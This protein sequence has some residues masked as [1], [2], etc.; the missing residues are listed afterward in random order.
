MNRRTFLEL[1]MAASASP[2]GL[3][4]GGQSTQQQPASIENGSV[5]VSANPANGTF[6][7]WWRG[8]RLL[9]DA[10]AAASSFDLRDSRYRRS[11]ASTAIHDR[12]GTGRQLTL[13]AADTRK[14]ADLELRITVY[15]GLEACF[16]ELGIRNAS[17]KPLPLSQMEP[18]RAHMQESAALVWECDK[19]LTNGYIYYDPGQVEDFVFTSRRAIESFWNIALHDSGSH[20]TLMIGSIDNSRTDTKVAVMREPVAVWDRSVHGLS[21]TVTSVLNRTFELKP[22]EMITSGKIM[23]HPGDNPFRVLERF[24]STYGAAAA[25]KLNPVVNGWCSWFYTHRQ[26]TEDEVL[27]NAEFVAKHLK[28]YG[29]NVIQIDDGYYRVFGDWEGNGRF[30]H[31]M[32]WLAD[33]IRKMGLVPGLWVAP[34]VVQ[35]PAAVVADHPEILVRGLDNQIYPIQGNDTFAVDVTHPGGRKWLYELFDTIANK[36]GYDFIKI[37]FV[38]WSLLAAPRYHDASVSRAQA[39]RMGFETLREA[40]GPHRHLL[41]CGPA[42]NTA[43]LLDSVRSELDLPELTWGQYT[44]P[45]NGTAAA[46]AR[47]YYFHGRTWITDV[48]HVG[49]GWLTP[50]QANAAATLVAMSGGTIISGDRLI[51]LDPQRAETLSRILPAYGEAARPLDLFRSGLARTFALPIHRDFGDWIVLAVFNYDAK[52]PLVDNINLVEADL[53][54]SKTYVAFEFW[55]QQLLGQFQ[56]SMP[57]NLDPGSVQLIALREVRPYPQIV[58]TSRHFTQGGWELK[59]QKWAEPV[60][61]GVLRG[62]AG[63]SNEIYIHLPPGWIYPG[64]DTP[65]RYDRADYTVKVFN[66]GSGYTGAGLQQSLLRLLFRF[67][68]SGDQSFTVGFK[69]SIG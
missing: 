40:A 38:E 29:M 33:E 20:K 10:H 31:G 61:G 44:N 19:I 21:L 60:L 14:E 50:G 63:T 28:P 22:G 23:L 34:Y 13:S 17:A 1:T 6:S 49:L 41:D 65:Y 3:A 64:D 52:S 16:V 30:K 18:V 66:P 11:A 57:V 55:T 7:A 68:Q 62:E 58:G 37:D 36:W 45:Q 42:Q 54:A 12:I 9:L 47:R 51:D 25:V 4:A 32:K 69:R 8:D 2:G 56:R 27:K 5:R 43:G 24:A 15:D 59:D 39:Y 26:V 67:E 53:D 48:D 46:A 35:K